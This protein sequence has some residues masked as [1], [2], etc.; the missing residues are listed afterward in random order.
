[1]EVVVVVVVVIVKVVVVVIINIVSC[2][3]DLEY[4]SFLVTG[5]Q[6]THRQPHHNTHHTNTHN[7]HAL[8]KRVSL[9]RPCVVCVVGCVVRV[10]PEV[11]IS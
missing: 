9:M 4:P 3:P 11:F 1:M 5:P 2:F 8:M 10:L 6:A 7:T